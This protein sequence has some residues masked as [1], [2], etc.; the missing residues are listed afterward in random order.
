MDSFECERM[1]LEWC[2]YYSVTDST[3]NRTR[4]LCAWSAAWNIQESKI[5]ELQNALENNM[6]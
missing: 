5:K 1:F 6:P 4:I 3:R 2:K